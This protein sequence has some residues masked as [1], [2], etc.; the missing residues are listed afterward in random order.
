MNR[1]LLEFIEPSEFIN[2]IPFK[3]YIELR[4]IH[5][6]LQ[7]IIYT[8]SLPFIE[9]KIKAIKKYILGTAFH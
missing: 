3:I 7:K 1:K 6:V 5:T 8:S 4:N 2:V 9:R